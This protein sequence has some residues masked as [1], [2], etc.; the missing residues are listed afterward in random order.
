MKWLAV[1]LTKKEPIIIISDL[2]KRW[3]RIVDDTHVSIGIDYTGADTSAQSNEP[4]RLKS[5]RETE[6]IH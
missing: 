6:K 3:N 4:I 5:K 2:S 1:S